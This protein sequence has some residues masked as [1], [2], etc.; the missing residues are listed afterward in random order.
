M[1]RETGAAFN[2]PRGSAAGHP[3]CPILPGLSLTRALW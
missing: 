2:L 3:G 1:L